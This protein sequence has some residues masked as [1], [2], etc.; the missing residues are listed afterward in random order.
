MARPFGCAPLHAASLHFFPRQH[1]GTAGSLRLLLLL[2]PA[3]P[4][5]LG[6]LMLR[7]CGDRP[8]G[9]SMARN[10]P[11]PPPPGV[12]VGDRLRSD[13][14]GVRGLDMPGMYAPARKQ[15]TVSYSWQCGAGTQ[16][17]DIPLN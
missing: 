15:Q 5:M 13:M 11:P 4:A 7:R 10:P 3:W 1:G 12:G 16:D 14:R 9:S 6:E 17:Q 2:L 8:R